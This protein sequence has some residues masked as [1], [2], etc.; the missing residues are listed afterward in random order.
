MQKNILKRFLFVASILFIVFLVYHVKLKEYVTLENFKYYREE[1]SSFVQ[2]NYVKSVI[3]Y[4]LIFMA[5]SLF[6]I[7][8]AM[9][10]TVVA[11]FFF[12]VF[13]GVLYTNIGS[14]IGSVFSFLFYRYFIGFQ[15]QMKYGEKL[16]NF[17]EHL[18]RDGSSYL[19]MM[20]F[21][22]LTPAFLINLSAG[23]SKLSLWT[24]IWTTS[25]G[26]LPGSLIYTFAGKKLLTIESTG[27]ILTWP[28]ILL[29]LSLCLLAFLPLILKRFYKNSH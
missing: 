22:P 6:T 2:V 17:N 20:Q 16:K 23:L 9:L 13:W 14:T 28:V 12:G 8:I 24:F 4:L 27:E 21:V 29:L 7:P 26:I 3:A 25:L 1:I 18:A 15:F 11:G 10:L 5:S 19:L